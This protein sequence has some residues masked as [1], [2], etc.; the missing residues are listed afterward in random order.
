M[1][2]NQTGEHLN[3]SSRYGLLVNNRIFFFFILFG[4][5][6]GCCCFLYIMLFQIASA[7]CVIEITL[8]RNPRNPIRVVSVA[9]I[10]CLNQM[11]LLRPW[12]TIA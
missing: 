6:N 1:T 4:M 11:E 10:H 7:E 2:K 3:T 8:T 5:R 12:Q 9:F